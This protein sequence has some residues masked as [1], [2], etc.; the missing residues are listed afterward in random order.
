MCYLLE[1]ES[2]ISWYSCTR[3]YKGAIT[4]QESSSSLASGWSPGETLGKSKKFNFLLGCP[5]MVGI[6]LGRNP[7]V[8][9]F[10]YSR[11]SPG[12]QLPAKEPEDSGYEI[13]SDVTT[14]TKH[15][16]N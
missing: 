10:Q 15:G 11:V 14:S 13:G 6:V 4:Y 9:N 2:F 5:V 12:G 7:A 8:K 3:F 16:N 1:Q